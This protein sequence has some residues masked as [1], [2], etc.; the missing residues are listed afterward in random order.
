MPPRRPAALPLAVALAALLHLAA[1]ASDSPPAGVAGALSPDDLN[2]IFVVTPDLA[3]QTPGDVSPVTGNLTNQGL[4]RSLALATYLKHQVLGDRNVTRIYG[5][6]PM[7]HLQTS[8]RY[9][10][11]A[12]L[13]YIQQFAMLN[14]ISLTA[15]G[16]YN[17]PLYTA[18]SSP[19]NAS[20]IDP[21]G[22]GYALAYQGLE[23]DDV[24]G[25]NLL[26]AETI[27]S[28]GA[29]GFYVLAAPWETVN[30]LLASLDARGQLGLAI[31]RKVS[32][33]LA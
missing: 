33:L 7:T 15:Q 16:G 22:E 30:A 17:S 8:D 12:A 10:D 24:S 29:P 25:H 19:L 21:D 6:Q 18:N 20:P 13:A 23:F 5:L 2:L 26:L 14:Q 9:P 32:I 11:M 31:T 1:C 27:V 3:Y 28:G 4:Q